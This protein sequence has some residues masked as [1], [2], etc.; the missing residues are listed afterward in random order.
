VKHLVVATHNQGKLKE[1]RE[2]LSDL[3]CR[4][5]SLADYDTPFDIVEDADTFEGNALKKARAVV[6]LTGRPALSDDSGL[7]V[8]A[9]GGAPGVHSARYGGLDDRGRYQRLL[10]AL[11]DI[12]D[13]RR[14]ARFRAAIVYLE[15]GG[16][17]EFFDGVVNGVIG[18]EARGDHGFGYDPVFIPEGHQDP[19][20][21]LGPE[22]KS[23]I[24]HRA[25]ALDA[26]LAYYSARYSSPE[27]P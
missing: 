23:H 5:T 16:D 2:R 1:I 3:N 22:I 15:P 20:A 26:F 4:V 12:P 9:L 18:H 14:T 17:P 19:M 7:E 8:D 13:E 6:E 21:V 10:Q 25:R 11:A 24:S 27:N